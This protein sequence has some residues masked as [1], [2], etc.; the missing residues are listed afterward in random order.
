[1][2]NTYIV[3]I[4]NKKENNNER[5]REKRKRIEASSSGR[6]REAGYFMWL[7]KLLEYYLW[8]VEWVSIGIRTTAAFVKELK[9]WKQLKWDR[10]R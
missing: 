2:A 1:M 4:Y 8:R 5:K 9:L 10:Q 3:Y 6:E 7:H